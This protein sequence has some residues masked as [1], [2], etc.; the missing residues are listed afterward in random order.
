[1]DYRTLD[2]NRQDEVTSLFTS[3]FTSSEGEKEGRLIGNLVSKLSSDI[4]NQEIICFGAYE[5]ETIIGAIF[6]TPLRFKEE[7]QVYL[8]APVA[9][10]TKH[11][12]KGIG[13]ALINY[14]INELKKRSVAVAI[15]YGDPSFYS[16]VGFQS[17]SESVIQ[18]P[19]KLS[20][21]EGW[22]GQ[23]LTG[24]PIKTINGRPT[25]VKEFNDPAY[26]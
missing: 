1:M 21:P 23:S 7:I 20:M 15:T 4:D 8:L 25:C 26:W 12:G 14:G 24:E 17:L 18:A 11:Q 22:L 19:L 5:E 3:V 10:N 16:K 2:K 13:Q 6:F 9:V